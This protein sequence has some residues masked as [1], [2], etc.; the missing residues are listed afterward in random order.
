MIRALAGHGDQAFTPP[1]GI[2]FADID[3]ESG[4][5]AGSFCT[6]VLREAFIAGTEP[7]ERCNTHTV[8]VVWR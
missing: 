8:P 1:D 3:R 2:V 7:W 4:K 6:R 5:I